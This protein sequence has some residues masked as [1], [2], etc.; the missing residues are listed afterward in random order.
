M[1]GE[2]GLMSTQRP[3]SERRG[4]PSLVLLLRVLPL[5][6]ALALAA[7]FLAVSFSLRFLVCSAVKGSL[8]R[9]YFAV[10]GLAQLPRT[11]WALTETVPP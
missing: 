7:A 8:R 6:L 11:P 9:L 3:L 5:A 1:S 2:P 10:R 4:P